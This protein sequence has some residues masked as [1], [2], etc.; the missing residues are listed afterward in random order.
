MT[1]PSEVRARRL[2]DPHRSG[3]V[4]VLLAMSLT[5]TAHADPV[6]DASYE[7]YYR[8]LEGFQR[9]DL[10]L[11]LSATIEDALVSGSHLSRPSTAHKR[12]QIA[13]LTLL[14]ARQQLCSP[15]APEV[16]TACVLATRQAA[17]EATVRF[18]SDSIGMV[19]AVCARMLELDPPEI[20]CGPR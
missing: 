10:E 19:A 4:L 8:A 6:L 5:I 16:R 15:G 14:S 13:D 12:R 20:L 3:W 1:T 17:E 11:E 18:N 2:S 7:E 9:R